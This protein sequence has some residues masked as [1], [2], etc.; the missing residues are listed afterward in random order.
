MNMNCNNVNKVKYY[1]QHMHR[2]GKCSIP[3]IRKECAASCSC[4]DDHYSQV[5][6]LYTSASCFSISRPHFQIS[7]D[8]L[9]VV[10]SN[11]KSPF[12][13]LILE[14]LHNI[15]QSVLIVYGNSNHTTMIVKEG[16]M[17]MY[18]EHDSIDFTGIIAL[19][20]HYP[21]IKMRIVFDRIFYMHDTMRIHKPKKFME[22]MRSYN[23][24]RTCGLQM[25]Q[26]MNIGM[27]AMHD[28]LTHR[29]KIN[30]LRGKSNP[31]HKERMKL[32]LKGMHGS[33]GTLFDSFGA[34][35]K[36]DQCGCELSTGPHIR[37]PFNITIHNK[38]YKRMELRYNY[39][40]MSKYQS[41][42]TNIFV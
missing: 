23:L 4:P 28:I 42:Q 11:V 14:S 29:H 8:T 21:R 30:T 31:T 26:S 27:Y 15:T 1:C 9:V 10:N 33:E 2:Q 32:K 24:S 34:W 17:S 19:V 5:S 16:V 37:R 3:S 35:A 25:G 22:A 13:S 40:G 38:T 39:W 41:R 36:Y 7:N 12:A 6:G 18:V 20:D